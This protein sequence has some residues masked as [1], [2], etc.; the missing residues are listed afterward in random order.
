M[1]LCDVMKID[2]YTLKEYHYIIC[3]FIVTLCG[4]G[5]YVNNQMS[6]QIMLGGLSS[7]KDMSIEHSVLDMNK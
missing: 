2:D 1:N 3:N 7:L 5:Q 6:C 4:H